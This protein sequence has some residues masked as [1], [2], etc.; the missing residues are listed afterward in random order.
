RLWR[1]EGDA[2][3]QS[4]VEAVAGSN[5]TIADGHHRYATALTYLDERLAQGDLAEDA[6]E[7]YV[8][9]GLIEEDEPGLVVLPNHRLVRAEGLSDDF[10]E[11]LGELYDVQL[12]DAPFGVEAARD[13]WQRVQANAL[14]PSTFG[15]L[16]LAEHQMYLATAHS[17]AAIDAAMPA[18]LSEASKR[19]D[20]LVLTETILHPL[21]G[22]DPD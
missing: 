3:Q 6:P 14:G 1:I 8:L 9:C 11:R 19:L 16:D 2:Q 21:L 22:I 18:Q 20:A 5:V 7:R 10:F 4:L 13:L 15:V 17:Q 12:I